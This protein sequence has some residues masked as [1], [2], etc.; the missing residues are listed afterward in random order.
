MTFRRIAI[1]IGVIGLSAG[2][3]LSAP[4]A[5]AGTVRPA[6][7]LTVSLDC[8][9]IGNSAYQC[10]ADVTGGVAPYTVYDSAGAS[11]SGSQS[12]ACDPGTP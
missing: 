9:A 3:A 4:N 11:A 7:A 6:T 1:G 8:E 10:F 5:A 2:A 12:F